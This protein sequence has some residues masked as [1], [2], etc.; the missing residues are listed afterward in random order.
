MNDSAS[1]NAV[2]IYFS[3]V[4]R[5]LN[6]FVLQQLSDLAKTPGETP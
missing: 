4:F 5:T 2:A 1:E 6:S 3:Y